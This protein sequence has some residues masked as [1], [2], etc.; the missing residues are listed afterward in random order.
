[1]PPTLAAA[2]SRRSAG[3]NDGKR[4]WRS[5]DMAKTRARVRGRI[6]GGSSLFPPAI[7][8]VLRSARFSLNER[9]AREAGK[10]SGTHVHFLMPS[11]CG[12]NRR[13]MGRI[14]GRGP[15]LEGPIP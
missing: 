8:A 3:R 7:S 13:V 4:D 14:G 10:N 15:S 12:T 6:A 5:S 11:R 2:A 1:M 9:P